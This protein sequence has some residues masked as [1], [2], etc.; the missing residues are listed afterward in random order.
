MQTGGR[1][2]FTSPFLQRIEALSTPSKKRGAEKGNRSR[3]PSSRGVIT[4]FFGGLT[5]EKVGTTDRGGN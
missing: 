1:Q 2:G 4:T 3:W 5:W